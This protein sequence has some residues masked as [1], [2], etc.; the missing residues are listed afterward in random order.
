MRIKPHQTEA[1]NLTYAFGKPMRTDDSRRDYFPPDAAD[2]RRRKL[3][4]PQ[5]FFSYITSNRIKLEVTVLADKSAKDT[6]THASHTRIKSG[7]N[8][9]TRI[10]QYRQGRTEQSDPIE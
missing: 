1:F 10:L 6:P 8:T 5:Y 2:A 3:E 9:H 4:I 7:G